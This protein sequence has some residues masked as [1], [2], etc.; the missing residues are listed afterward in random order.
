MLPYKLY[1]PF[2]SNLH[3]MASHITLSVQISAIIQLKPQT[4]L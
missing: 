4:D 1:T 2:L 3:L